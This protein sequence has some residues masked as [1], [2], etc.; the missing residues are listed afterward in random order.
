MLFYL[1][2]QKMFQQ[3]MQRLVLGLWSMKVLE[4]P[5]SMSP[6]VYQFSQKIPSRIALIGFNNTQV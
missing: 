1:R 3:R 5:C 6:L 2:F 4:H